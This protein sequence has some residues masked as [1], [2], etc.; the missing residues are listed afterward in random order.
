MFRSLLM[1]LAFTALLAGGLAHSAHAARSEGIVAIVND[2]PITASDLSD[3]M[4]LMI[5][6]SGL[7]NTAEIHERLKNQI[8][9]MLIEESLQRLEAKTMNLTVTEEEIEGGFA[10]IAQQNNM[11]VDQFKS[12]LQRSGIPLRTLRDQISAQLAWGK[13]VQRRIRPQVNVNDTDIDERLRMMESN[14]GKTQYR[15][16]EIFLPVDGPSQDGEVS[17]LAQRLVREIA[18]KRAPFPQIANQ[19]SQGAAAARGGD[20]DWILEGQLPDPLNQVVAGMKDGDLSQ[21]VRSMSGYHILLLR[22]TRVIAPENIPDRET[23]RNQIGNERLD[24]AQ[25]RYLMDLKSEAF[26][27][28]RV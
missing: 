15:V 6:S 9:N 1:A 4:K 8:L 27:E 28:R 10:T 17:A 23:I 20:L 7:P 18:E 26:V 22:G 21:P 16:A 19:F 11:S 2:T 12:V 14:I 24:R 13:V 5:V 25:R 3:R